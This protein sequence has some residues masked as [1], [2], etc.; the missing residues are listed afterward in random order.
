MLQGHLHELFQVCTDI[1]L[2]LHHRLKPL[3]QYFRIS[4]F[5]LSFPVLCS[6][7]LVV[8]L[9]CSFLLWKYTGKASFLWLHDEG[10]RCI[11]Y[12][13]WQ[14]AFLPLLSQS[15]R[16]RFVW[17]LSIWAQHPLWIKTL[18]SW[19]SSCAYIFSK[20]VPSRYLRSSNFLKHLD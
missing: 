5:T 8:W 3:Y 16:E 20:W 9:K 7:W 2:I 14:C 18:H 11:W 13:L 4:S 15:F 10:L 19:R 12:W 6:I 17:L 1:G